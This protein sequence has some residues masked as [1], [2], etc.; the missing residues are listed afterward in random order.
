M[1]MVRCY[2]IGVIT[3][4]DGGELDCKILAVP[5]EDPSF[6]GYKDIDDIP[7]I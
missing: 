5:F 7:L 1:A 2:P 3:M 4:M 6:R